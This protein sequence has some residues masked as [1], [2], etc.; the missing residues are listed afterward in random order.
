MDTNLSKLQEIVEDRGAWCAVV[1][2]VTKSQEQLSDWTATK[3]KL[4]GA[5]LTP[6]T[7]SWFSVHM[8]PLPQ[9]NPIIASQHMSLR[10]KAIS[11]PP[12]SHMW[13]QSPDNEI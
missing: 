6:E 5:G 4:D 10:V 7:E 9:Q 3:A 13:P 8:Y 11:Q 1:H 12:Y 2:E